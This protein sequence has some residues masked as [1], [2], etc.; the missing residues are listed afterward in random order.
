MPET[1]PV[2]TI[3]HDVFPDFSTFLLFDVWS[4]HS[5]GDI[6]LPASN[7]V[8]ASGR[9]GA[10]FY[11]DD[12][13]AYPHVHLEL[14]TELPPHEPPGDWDRYTGELTCETGKLMLS[15]LTAS[16]DDKPIDLPP[17][18]Y[19]MRA[20]RSRTREPYHDSDA[21]DP[22]DPHAFTQQW[23]IQLALDTAS[24]S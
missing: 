2:F 23:I 3:D 16:P 9:G 13:R 5:Y 21:L 15:C 24:G 17:G 8:A 1:T 22:D 14:W 10:M 11:T 6:T 12:G 7:P 20:L 4:S 19:R 18:R